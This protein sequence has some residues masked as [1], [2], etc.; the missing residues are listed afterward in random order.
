MPLSQSVLWRWQ[1]VFYARMG[2]RA[3]SEGIVPWRITSSPLHAL[4][5]ARVIAGFAAD[6]GEPVNVV[7]LGAGTGRFAFHLARFLPEGA[8]LTVTDAAQANVDALVERGLPFACVRHDALHPAPPPGVDGSRPTVFIGNYLFDSLPHDAFSLEGRPLL[9]TVEGPD[10]DVPELEQVRWRFSP[11]ARGVRLDPVGAKACLEATHWAARSLFLFA[12]KVVDGA[13]PEKTEPPI[14]RHGCFSLPVNLE[15]LRQPGRWLAPER[16]D[17]RFGTFGVLHGLTDAQLPKTKAA[18]GALDAAVRLKDEVDAALSAEPVDSDGLAVL[19]ERSGHDPDLLLRF[20]EPLRARPPSNPEALTDAVMTAVE[21]HFEL[22]EPHDV[23]FEA[24][25][26]LHRAGQL[27]KA[28]GLYQRSLKLRGEH[29]TVWF[30]LALCALDAGALPG[31]LHALE[32]VLR[33]EP[34][35]PRA[36]P[37]LEQLR[38]SF[39]L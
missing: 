27:S 29:P 35:H 38:T 30:N 17:E 19:L 4:G 1:S 12:D 36:A 7:E 8:A 9:I 32:A 24:A 31:A 33:L 20:A 34:N 10:A 18:F 21:H 14:A 16:V 39:P 23:V 25:T 37:L 11:D 15:A 3:W 5:C 13:Q 26:V 2:T 28:A 6:L 22:G